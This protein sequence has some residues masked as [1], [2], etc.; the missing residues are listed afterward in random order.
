MRLR[1]TS[2][3]ILK[4]KIIKKKKKFKKLSWKQIQEPWERKW[5]QRSWVTSFI[6]WKSPFIAGII[7]LLT[8]LSIMQRRKK[9]NS[10]YNRLAQKGN[11]LYGRNLCALLFF[12]FF[13]LP[14]WWGYLCIYGFL[15]ETGGS[16]CAL[17]ACHT[18]SESERATMWA[19]LSVCNMS[20]RWTL[21]RG[22][23]LSPSLRK[24][25]MRRSFFCPRR[26]FVCF[27]I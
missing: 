8:S 21:S 24:E 22:G 19:S 20:S 9:T 13:F 12:F 2:T 11:E 26:R 10:S 5:R 25:E 7:R 4:Y 15:E 27:F 23:L 1:E 17:C 3:L 14:A 16:V 18:E 6:Y